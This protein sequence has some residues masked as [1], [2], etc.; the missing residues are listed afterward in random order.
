VTA[1]PGAGPTGSLATALAHAERLLASSPRLAAEQATEILRVVPKHPSAELLLAAAKNRLGD[2]AGALEILEPIAQAHNDHAMVQYE[3][4]LA[5]G[6]L[7]HG[8]RAVEALRRAVELKPDLADAWRALA[9]HLVASGDPEEADAAYMRHLRLSTQDPRLLTA[10]AALVDNRLAPA[11]ALLRE[12]LKK[13]PTDIAAIRMLAEVAAR[14]GRMADAENLLA[15]CLE[16]APSFT[17]ARYNYASI[18]LKLGKPGEAYI[19]V[20]RIL[21]QDPRN[22]GYRHLKAAVLARIGEFDESLRI[23]AEVLGEYSGRAKSWMS[24][25]HALK[26]A[27]KTDASIA[28]YRRSIELSPSLGEVWWSLANI[29]TFRFTDADIAALRAG[30]ERTDLG[31]EDRYHFHFALGK[32][33]EDAGDWEG[34]FAHYREGNRIRR[35]VIQYDPDELANGVRQA[36]E[37]FTREFF[38]QRR[39]FGLPEPD[40][41]F[42]VGLPRAGSTLIEQIVSSHSL[43]EGTMELPD[44]IAIAREIGGRRRRGQPSKYPAALA[45]LDGEQTRALGQRYL[46]QTRIQRRTRAP[47]FVDKMPNNFAHVALIHLMLPKAKIIDVRRHPLGCCFSVFKQHFA[48]GQ[49]FSYDLAE[50]GRYYRDYVELMAHFD[51][52]LPGR[53]HRVIYEEMVGNTEAEV[54]R[55]LAYCE[56]PFEDSCLRFYE[57]K[58]PVRTASSE[59]VRQPIYREGID[60]WRHFEP[61]LAPLKEA[62]GPVLT[63]WPETPEF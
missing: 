60:H 36:K 29:K 55:L 22:P 51:A 17:A 25:G 19:E 35:K 59:Q 7:R 21:A 4:G 30:A 16:L 38:D 2:A 58:R 44:V 27:G 40:P 42:V 41:I 15:R 57:N 46:D 24:Y 52:V 23:Y 56:L 37:L 33:L 26:S 3:L 1:E 43:V 31:I 54:R 20:D 39:D 34:S 5:H 49:H 47:F 14:L 9:D 45:M 63:A 62:L 10:A 53:V 61:W 6:A 48:R 18:L 50:L 8:E 28:A 32:A 13:H 11:E 12:H